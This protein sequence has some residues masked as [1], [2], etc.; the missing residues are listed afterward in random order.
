MPEIAKN[1]RFLADSSEIWY[2]GI[3]DVR[4]SESKV[5]FLKFQNPIWQ[6][7]CFLKIVKNRTFYITSVLLHIQYTGKSLVYST[8]IYSV[9]TVICQYI[10]SIYR[11]MLVY[12]GIYFFLCYILLYTSISLVY[13]VIYQNILSIY[14]YVI[15]R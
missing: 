5:R 8:S 3:S 11:Y 2:T 10:L 6:L 12:T 4:E 14:C 15:V 7:T 13:T 9:Y 1:R